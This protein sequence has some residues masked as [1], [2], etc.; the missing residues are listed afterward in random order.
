MSKAL[1]FEPQLRRELHFDQPSQQQQLQQQQHMQLQLQQQHQKPS[2]VFKLLA[3]RSFAEAIAGQM[4]LAR[5]REE[6]GCNV[7]MSPWGDTFPGTN[8]QVVTCMASTPD[9]LRQGLLAVVKQFELAPDID[10]HDDVS[11]RFIAPKKMSSKIIGRGG[12]N[13][14]ALFRSTRVKAFI[15]VESFGGNGVGADQ[16]VTMFGPIEGMPEAVCIMLE[17]MQELTDQPWYADWV[18]RTNQDRIPPPGPSGRSGPGSYGGVPGWEGGGARDS[19]R[20]DSGGKGMVVHSKTPAFQGMGLGGGNV[21]DKGGGAG[22]TK[23]GNGFGGDMGV[24][25]SSALSNPVDSRGG[26][27]KGTGRG[28]DTCV[29]GCIGGMAAGSE[30]SLGTA[31]GTDSG[32][33][34]LGPPGGKSGM[35][36]LTHVLQL[37]PQRVADDPRGF[38]LRCAV[39]GRL[40][41][42]TLGGDRSGA[43]DVES[44][45][46]V[47]IDI[48]KKL[49]EGDHHAMSITGPLFGTV[50]AYIRMMK[51]YLETEAVVAN[52]TSSPNSSVAVGQPQVVERLEQQLRAG[53]QQLQRLQRMSAGVEGG[54]GL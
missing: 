9:S 15:D 8:D 14:K 30:G 40:L 1:D 2:H 50:A 27:C 37:V 3:S 31:S 36:V 35:D 24:V 44:A 25:A 12:E 4:D 41:D 17:H 21:G 54:N 23:G 32:R 13:V 49:L 45:T 16:L 7:F 5:V 33:R 29:G 38:S 28:G 6:T 46:G 51:R 34:I 18:V 20:S 10:Q 22:S 47:R 39:P 26:G 43:Q 19:G 48:A 42:G 53:G 52:L 11:L